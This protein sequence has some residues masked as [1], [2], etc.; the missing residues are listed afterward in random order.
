[1]LAKGWLSLDPSKLRDLILALIHRVDILPDRVN[2]RISPAR[3]SK[4]LG[5]HAK[6]PEKEASEGDAHLTL[7][8]PA[9]L[10]R[11]GME[12]KMLV[13]G[14][15]QNT[16][17]ADRSLVRLIVKAHTLREKLES[18]EGI[19]VGGMTRRWGTGRVYV[20]RLL[21]LSFL[22]P[23]ITK[24]ILEGRHPKDLTASRLMRETRLPIAWKEQREAL[25]F[26]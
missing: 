11:A 1:M 13:E 23:D 4:M 19:D 2:I 6:T 22:A 5:G 10:K 20:M 18:K 3:L 25:G 26:A 9:R 15:T 17:K 8:V 24:A 7:T 14:Q 21:R 16:G 12:M